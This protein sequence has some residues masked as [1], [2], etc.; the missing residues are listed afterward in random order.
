MMLRALLADMSMVAFD[1]GVASVRCTPSVRSIAEKKLDDLGRLM[2]KLCGTTVRVVL[3]ETPAGNARHDEAGVGSADG[4]EGGSE[5]HAAAGE[6]DG[7]A[8]A[9][10]A[11]ATL[12]PDTDHPIVIKTL[13]MFNGRIV[14]VKPV[15]KKPLDESP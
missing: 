14:E 4:S 11:G 3:V 10:D 6:I 15:R 2:S 5:S 7:R 12:P 13:E 8:Q 9:V 1:G